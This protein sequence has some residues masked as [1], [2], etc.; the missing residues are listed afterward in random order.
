MSLSID[1]LRMRKKMVADAMLNIHPR[2]F[3]IDREIMSIAIPIIQT[4]LVPCAIII[5]VCQEILCTYKGNSIVVYLN[6][7]Q[8]LT[9][10]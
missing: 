8:R 9:K 1:V 10:R 4:L 6:E 2:P 5:S 7:I 3:Y